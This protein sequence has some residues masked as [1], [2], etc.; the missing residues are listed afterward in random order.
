MNIFNLS[1]RAAGLHL[2]CQIYWH[3][4]R[5]CVA[6]VT[7]CLAVFAVFCDTAIVHIDIVITHDILPPIYR[8]DLVY[9]ISCPR[10]LRHADRQDW[11]QTADPLVRGQLLYPLNHGC[12]ILKFRKRRATWKF[13]LIWCWYM[14][15][16]HCFFPPNCYPQQQAHKDTATQQ[17]F[18]HFSW[19][20]QGVCE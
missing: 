20:P 2:I 1:L 6:H 5:D 16:A 13:C 7:Q 8:A 15:T 10:T 12:P 11:D 3:A 9:F 14:L 19:R 18:C 17:A 4:V